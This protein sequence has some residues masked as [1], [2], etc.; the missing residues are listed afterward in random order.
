MALHVERRQGHASKWLDRAAKLYDIRIRFR[1]IA[2]PASSERL[3]GKMSKAA[4]RLS[5]ALLLVVASL[6]IGPAAAQQTAA[7]ACE[8]T[9]SWS[10]SWGDMQLVQSDSNVTGSYT[11][12]AGT[13]E[14]SLSGSILTG[15]W[16]EAPS[17]SEPNDAGDIVFTFAA[18]CT[19]MTGKWRYG[20]SGSWYEDW[21]GTRL[22]SEYGVI[23][24]DGKLYLVSPPDGPL[25]ISRDDLPAWARDQIVTVGAVIPTVGFP[26]HVTEGDP[27]ILIG[28]RAVA[29]LGDGTAHGGRIVEGSA[30]IFINGVPAAFRGGYAVSPM[31][32]GGWIPAVGGV[33]NPDC[34]LEEAALGTAAALQDCLAE[35]AV[36][37]RFL[38]QAAASGDTVLEVDTEGFE[39]GDGVMIASDIGRTETA[40]VASK[41][42]IVLDRPLSQAF[43]VGSL[44]TRIPD[45]YVDQIPPP[46]AGP[47]GGSFSPDIVLG[48]NLT[49]Y[50]GGT[51]AQL[52]S[53][54]SSFGASSIAVSSQG[55]LIVLVIGAPTFVNV[56]FEAHFTDGVP[57]AAVMIVL[58]R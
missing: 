41:G 26:D 31:I 42:S 43:P 57:P 29:R 51:V 30:T 38:E 18:D 9:G 40:R 47:P 27:L 36:A 48:V 34:D 12:D 11:W 28:G 24:R 52:A 46:L 23:E 22:Q 16:A 33:I 15:K 4:F 17:Y 14:G 21:S 58:V 35:Y 5:V 56:A 39:V 44:I 19:S 3:E 25:L 50:S 6:Q 20:S 32:F 49:T 13:I 45:E 8:V 1:S 10:S 54:A 55:S 7:P 53:D 37:I 2:H